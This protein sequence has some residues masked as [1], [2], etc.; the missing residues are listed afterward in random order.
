MRQ[1]MPGEDKSV[2]LEGNRKASVMETKVMWLLLQVSIY[3]QRLADS[4][5]LR[6]LHIDKDR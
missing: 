1:K 5:A 3:S 6:V 4:S 2:A